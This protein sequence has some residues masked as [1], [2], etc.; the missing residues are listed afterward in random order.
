METDERQKGGSCFQAFRSN[1]D[2]YITGKEVATPGEP[3][4][5]HQGTLKKTNQ[6]AQARE[7]KMF[8]IEM[9]C[10]IHDPIHGTRLAASSETTPYS[11]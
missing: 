2:D 7:G 4:L 10:V 1:G 8:V 11:S 9:E 3:R 5:L 6:N